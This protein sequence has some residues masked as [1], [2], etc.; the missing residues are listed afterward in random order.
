MID[1][2]LYKNYGAALIIIF[3]K[4]SLFYDKTRSLLLD[5]SK[6]LFCDKNTI[7]KR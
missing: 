4:S 7:P 1:N 5:K 2:I 6:S 3:Y